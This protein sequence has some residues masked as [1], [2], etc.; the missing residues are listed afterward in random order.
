VDEA[1][2][3]CERCGRDRDAFAASRAAFRDCPACGSACCPDC[4]N[5]VDGACL[6]CAPFRL[7]AETSRSHVV[8][9][10]GIDGYGTAAA[11]PAEGPAPPS[12]RPPHPAPDPYADLRDA[13]GTASG[14]DPFGRPV[15]PGVLG[16]WE[17]TRSTARQRPREAP[18]AG[19]APG[20]PA[21]D[22]WR[23]VM[24][25]A[26][27][28]PPH[29]RRRRS[30]RVAVAAVASWIFV[31]ALAVAALGA[32]PGA[33][34]VAKPTPVPA[35]PALLP[36]ALPTPA[37]VATPKPTVTPKPK[38]QKAPKATPKPVRR[39]VAVPPAATAKPRTKATPRPK[40]PAVVTPPPI[41]PPP[42]LT[43]E[44]PAP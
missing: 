18:A 20:G 35:A 4:W 15:D 9:A 31:A 43:P 36:T 19:A 30:G 28:P 2:Q 12:E 44:T 40:E 14:I 10:A 33:T 7:R 22:A 37:P 5:L 38:P 34:A 23:A 11:P 25:A 17:A 8:P 39:D 29:R 42:T 41:A 26:D 32:N 21:P 13:P 27:P 6:A 16:S 1:I 3:F 24:A